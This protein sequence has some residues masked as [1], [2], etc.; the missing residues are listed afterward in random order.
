MKTGKEWSNVSAPVGEMRLDIHSCRPEELEP[1]IHLLDEEFIFGKGRSISLQRRFPA[2]YCSN[3]L[4]NIFL[5]T[6]GEAIV[7]ALAMRYF[8]WREGSE[9][10]RGAMIGAVY[11]QPA[12]RGQGLA[13]RLLATAAVQLREN[14]ID[15]AVLWTGQPSFY[16]RLGWVAAD[17]SLLGTILT[18]NSAMASSD[19]VTRMPIS[20]GASLAET[21]RQCTLNSMAVRHPE[22]YQQ[23]PLPAERVVF[24]WQKNQDRAAYALI[25]SNGETGFLYEL[26]GDI[27][28]FPELWREICRGHR[29]IFINDQAGSP[30]YRW[31]AEHTDAHWENKNLA[32]WLPLSKQVNIVR[33]GQWHIP[34]FDR[35]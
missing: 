11:T 8:D 32:M 28:C 15:F 33:L 20:A 19:A 7:S 12:R 21:I 3:N 9:I 13:S 5:C 27:S 22:D 24:L 6:D 23:L 1:L 26:V 31:L 14:N 16:S 34:Y 2:V 29:R 10:F 18:N 30:S 17:C 25:G 4:T 35:I